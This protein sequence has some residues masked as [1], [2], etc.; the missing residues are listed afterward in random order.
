[1]RLREVATQRCQASGS[2]LPGWL[3]WNPPARPEPYHDEDMGEVSAEMIQN[4]TI[5]AGTEGFSMDRSLQDDQVPLADPEVGEKR[6]PPHVS[7][8][9]SRFD[10][11]SA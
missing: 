4:E 10:S 7:D 9:L 8:A 1:M 5:E 11:P 3:K 2:E 6:Q